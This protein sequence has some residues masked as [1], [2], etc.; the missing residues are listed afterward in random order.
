[1]RFDTPRIIRKIAAEMEQG[2]HLSKVVA[3]QLNKIRPELYP[4]AKAWANGIKKS[5]E[6][7]GITLDEIQNRY[8]PSTPRVVAILTMN[9]YLENP[10]LI[11]RDRNLK[12]QFIKK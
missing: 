1:M 6:F 7:N 11:E 3:Q 8:N 5:F 2:E 12:I 10:A 4:V 9:S